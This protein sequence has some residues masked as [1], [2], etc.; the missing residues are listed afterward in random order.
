MNPDSIVRFSFR[1]L[2]VRG[3]LVRL[4]QS[5]RDA[6]AAQTYSSDTARRVGEAM[7]LAA[8][9]ADGIQF[10][11]RVAL[12][13]TSEGRIS[14]LLGECSARHQLR[15]IAR[16]R[17]APGPATEFGNGRL[18]ISLIPEQGEMHQGVVELI[19]GGLPAAIEHYFATSE[20]L[21]TRVLLAADGQRVAAALLQRMPLTTGLAPMAEDDWQRLQ[22]LFDTLASDELL[23]LQPQLLLQRL[24]HTD[25]L[26][27]HPARDLMFHC[28][29]SR[30]RSER[31]LR[32]LGKED[33]TA[34]SN[35]ADEITVSCEMCGAEYRWD[36]IEAHQIF[37]TQ[38]PQIH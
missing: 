20:Q 37:E 9:L 36:G 35:E 32:M 15:G 22:L 16:L 19:Q 13:A 14:T 11:G 4:Q 1:D 31:A 10:E 2:P 18:A 30:E 8:L 3:Q 28:N 26:N 34:L 27:L 17:E 5:W 12:Q 6:I 33:L 29:C 7:A 38:A 25:D 23:T 24:F 21:P